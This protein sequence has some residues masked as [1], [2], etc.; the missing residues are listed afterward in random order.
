M[1]SLNTRNVDYSGFLPIPKI[2]VITNQHLEE[3]YFYRMDRHL[4][5]FIDSKNLW[6]IYK[7]SVLG[8]YK[9]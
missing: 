1:I 4:R 3:I 2:L 7:R 6:E 8:E 9:K 5:E